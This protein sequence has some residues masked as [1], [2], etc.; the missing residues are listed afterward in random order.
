M[1]PLIRNIPKPNG[2][3]FPAGP[4]RFKKKINMGPSWGGGPKNGVYPHLPGGDRDEQ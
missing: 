3:G 4:I 1:G 2:P